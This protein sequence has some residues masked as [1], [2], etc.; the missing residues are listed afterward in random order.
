VKQ[1]TGQAAVAA[2]LVQWVLTLLVTTFRILQTVVEM[3]E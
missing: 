3:V 1:T 2:A